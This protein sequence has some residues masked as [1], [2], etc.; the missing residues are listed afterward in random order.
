MARA[1][2][3]LLLHHEYVVRHHAARAVRYIQHHTNGDQHVPLLVEAL[4]FWAD[5]VL[6]A[7]MLI[8]GATPQEGGAGTP[9]PSSTTSTPHDGD[10]T[11]SWCRGIMASRLIAALP[12]VAPPGSDKGALSPSLLCT[13]LLLAHHPSV[14]AGEGGC[15]YAWRVVR[16]ALGQDVVTAVLRGT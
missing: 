14:Q 15:G 16:R 4:I 9:P 5:H 11:A 2:V 10:P 6:D 1:L 3:L 8:G 12:T 13:L 7:A